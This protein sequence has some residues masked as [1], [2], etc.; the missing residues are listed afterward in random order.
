MTFS[1]LDGEEDG[2][3]NG[4]GLVWISEI[5]VTQDDFCLCVTPSSR[6]YSQGQVTMK[7][8]QKQH[9]S[10]MKWISGGSLH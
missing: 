3:Y 2:K 9:S 7:G 10:V 4:V 8:D 6:V 1:P 5:F